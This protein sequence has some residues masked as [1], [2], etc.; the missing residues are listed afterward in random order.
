MAK[1]IYVGNLS[2]SSTEEELIS[3][4][5]NFGEITSC[6][7]ISDRDTGRSRGFGFVEMENADEA[8]ESLQDA[9]LGGRTLVIN[10]ARERQ[11][12]RPYNGGGGGGGRRDRY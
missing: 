12:R 9:Q 2:Y 4:F 6:K 5:E 1:K 10:E 7:I 11:E 3:L 8:I